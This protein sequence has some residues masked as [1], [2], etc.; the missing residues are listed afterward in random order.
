MTLQVSSAVR[1]RNAV[2]AAGLTTFALGG[3]IATLLEPLTIA[4]AAEAVRKIREEGIPLHI[5]GAGSNVVIPDSGVSSPVITFGREFNRFELLTGPLAGLLTGPFELEKRRG[6][7]S[8]ELALD[9]LGEHVRILAFA[10]TPLMAL[11]RKLCA[12]G[13]S[14]LEFAA[15]IPASV[16]GA[17]RMNAGAHGEAIGEI[18][19]S[20]IYL[21]ATGE[22]QH[23]AA[24]SIEFRYRES[25][26]PSEAI[27]LAVELEL[28]RGAA[29]RISINRNRCLEHRRS[30]QPLHLPSSGS[31][32]R[33][34]SQETVASA[35]LEGPRSAGWLLERAGLKGVRRGGVE[36][37][38]LH[39][40]WLV[41]VEECATAADVCALVEL[42][43]QRV[44]QEFGVELKP[45]IVFW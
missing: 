8:A 24:E 43:Q 44:F 30:T 41:K 4:G 21:D 12:L 25:R 6:G 45:E 32:F 3:S 9:E 2:P 23:R 38:P 27:V 7:D 11:S 17:L 15:G 10:G 14:G 28:R 34:P 36:Y 19:R 13:L 20:V 22:L 40:N 37:S 29:E 33:N 39:A 18:T 35:T 42:G 5:L 31:V 16:G 26:L 1:V